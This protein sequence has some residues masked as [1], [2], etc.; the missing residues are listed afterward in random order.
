MPIGIIKPWHVAA[1]SPGPSL[2]TCLDHKHVGQWLRYDPFSKGSTAKPQCSQVNGS[3]RAINIKEAKDKEEANESGNSIEFLIGIYGVGILLY[4]FYFSYHWIL[5][6]K[7]SLIDDL[8]K[9]D[10][11]V[12]LVSLQHAVNNS[13]YL[14]WIF[15]HFLPLYSLVSRKQIF[16]FVSTGK[17]VHLLEILRVVYMFPGTIDQ[18]LSTQLGFRIVFS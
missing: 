3:W 2:S 9:V 14:L 18:L 1:R 6:L 17:S 13:A 15:L 12:R 10:S 4:V 11:R 16:V 5:L 7:D 8:V